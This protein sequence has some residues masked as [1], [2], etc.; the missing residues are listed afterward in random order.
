[1]ND[2]QFKFQLIKKLTLFAALLLVGI[3]A[4]LFFS[5]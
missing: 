2:D 4:I 3:A 5:H 1:M